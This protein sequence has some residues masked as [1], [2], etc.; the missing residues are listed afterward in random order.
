M[1]TL[2]NVN[3]FGKSRIRDRPI[4]TPLLTRLEK[5]SSEKHRKCSLFSESLRT[6]VGLR[7]RS[8]ILETLCQIGM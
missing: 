2:L 6:H 8:V 4:A 5:S 3:G 1:E 7:R